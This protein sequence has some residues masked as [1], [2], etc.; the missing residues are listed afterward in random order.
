MVIVQLAVKLPV[1]LIKHFLGTFS[2]D[3]QT[4][5][6]S[7]FLSSSSLA[8]FSSHVQR[9]FLLLHVWNI[10]CQR[11]VLS[12]SWGGRPWVSWAEGA[13]AG[14]TPSSAGGCS[15]TEGAKAGSTPFCNLAW[16][17]LQIFLHLFFWLL[18]GTVISLG[19]MACR[20][21]TSKVCQAL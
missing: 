5:A 10:S 6:S 20:N 16:S 1:C 12:F 9:L 3:H 14:R 4:P 21:N 13:T 17:P 19:I 11:T 8:L 15:A 2:Q 18:Q 7:A